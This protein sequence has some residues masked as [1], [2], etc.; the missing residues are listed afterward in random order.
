MCNPLKKEK[1]KQKKNM[2]KKKREGSE[3]TWKNRIRKSQR[4][5]K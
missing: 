2:G 5:E 3:E 4:T 1:K